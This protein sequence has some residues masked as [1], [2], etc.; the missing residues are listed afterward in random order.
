M[1]GVSPSA[2]AGDD[3]P[4]SAL[5]DPFPECTELLLKP[6]RFSLLNIFPAPSICGDCPHIHPE[7]KR[8]GVI[9]LFQLRR[10]DFVAKYTIAR[11]V[12]APEQR[13]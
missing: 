1:T 2:Q 7:E 6:Q 5:L 3:S 13:R 8:V 12:I 11:R 4:A 9:D 10:E